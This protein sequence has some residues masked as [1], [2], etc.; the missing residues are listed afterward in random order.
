MTETRPAV[1][2]LGAGD[3]ALG[4]FGLGL[5]AVVPGAEWLFWLGADAVT[6][7]AGL[8][9][10]M[11]FFMGVPLVLGLAALALALWKSPLWRIGAGIVLLAWV[12]PHDASLA[13]VAFPGGGRDM[14]LTIAEVGGI[15]GLNGLGLVVWGIWGL[16]ARLRSPAAVAR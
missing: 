4:V 8:L 13:A 2:E 11:A 7:L 14:V 1:S 5:L 12:A 16:M 3:V 10:G 6:S 15:P 9:F